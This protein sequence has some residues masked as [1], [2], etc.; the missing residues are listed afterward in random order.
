MGVGGGRCLGAQCGSINRD[1]ARHV[2]TNAPPRM[3]RTYGA[4]SLYLY[5]DAAHRVAIWPSPRED[6]P[7]ADPVATP[8]VP[9][10]ASAS[11]SP[12]PFIHQ[13][14]P[15]HRELH[16]AIQRERYGLIPKR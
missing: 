9:S 6:S 12:H 3:P 1:A 10:K 16:T 7:P 8:R 5:H 13:L 2:A 14:H 15:A 11:P 4:P